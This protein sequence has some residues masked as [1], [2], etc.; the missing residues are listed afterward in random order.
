M[1]KTKMTN[2][3]IIA[4]TDPTGMEINKVVFLTC[5]L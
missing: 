3:I 1:H 5:P 4:R 2:T